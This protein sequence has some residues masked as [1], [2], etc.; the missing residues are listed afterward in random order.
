M[1]ARFMRGGT[2]AAAALCLS[3]TTAL[4]GMPN[5]VPP[6][7]PASPIHAIAYDYTVAQVQQALTARG[8]DAGPADGL[9][10]S[11]TRSA[12]IAYQQRNNL[13]VT[14]QAS[15]SLLTHIATNGQSGGTSAA[16]DDDVN[17]K[18][19]QR[20][21]RRLGYDLEMT[22]RLDAQTAAAVRA[23]QRDNDLLVTGDL[24]AALQEHLRDNMREARQERRDDNRGTS[25]GVN[26]TTLA[27]IQRGL[28]ARG[29]DV[30]AADGGMD[31]KTAAAIS[32]YQRDSGLRETGEASTALAERLA[33]GLAQPVAT[34]ENI[35]QMQQALNSRG[36]SAGPADGVLGPSTRSAIQ[37]FRAN[38][39]LPDTGG[40]DRDL[41]SALGIAVGAGAGATVATGG[42]AGSSGGTSTGDY[43]LRIGDDFNDGNY[44]SGSRWSVIAGEF[45]VEQGALRS[46][47]ATATPQSQ[48]EIG[49]DMIQGVLGQVLGVPLGGAAGGADKAAAI[50]QDTGFGNAFKL[51]MRI[52]GDPAGG[53]A[54]MNI[55]PYQG[56]NV[57][58][59]YRLVYDARSARPLAIVATTDAGSR[60]AVSSASAPNLS[61]GQWHRMVWSRDSSG[62]ML[63]TIDDTPYLSVTDLGL[64][65]SNTGL[66]F[67]NL[68]GDWKLDDIAVESPQG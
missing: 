6:T 16:T 25:G 17:V 49:R 57:I 26:A 35:R 67:V 12:I 40:L 62:Q 59:G 39:D 52:A 54:K 66:S 7:A 21:L 51:T 24:N 28:R 19:S 63:V 45:Q 4:A 56:R 20:Q 10:G 48:Q 8:F 1:T 53:D 60:T 64:D 14:G 65:G 15:Q 36:Y 38:T 22:G 23:Y 27:E 41:L 18:R 58:Q 11:R 33:E 55:G 3:A 42:T 61:D 29:Y 44:T 2:L 68:G 37:S 43:R 32:A 47:L 46:R 30:T 34:P 13:L 9:M 31:D 5:A 50:S